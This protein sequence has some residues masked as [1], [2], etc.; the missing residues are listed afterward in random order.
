MAAKEGFSATTVKDS[1]FREIFECN[2][3][4]REASE[5]VVTC[6]GHLFCW[7]CLY[8]WLHV[9]SSRQ[10]C[11]VCK[12]TIEDGDVTPIYGPANSADALWA[13]GASAGEQGERLIPPRPPARRMHRVQRAQRL[14]EMWG[15]R[16]V[17]R[18]ENP[19]ERDA[20]PFMEDQPPRPDGDVQQML[21]LVSSIP[22]P[23]ET[24]PQSI[25]VTDPVAD[26][27][28]DTNLVIHFETG[29]SRRGDNIQGNILTHLDQRQRNGL[30]SL[31]NLHEPNDA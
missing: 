6:C 2:I 12:G 27:F 13:E 29:G 31:Q 7:P 18:G 8:M 17:R 22:L 19:L 9:H 23:D 24:G 21:Q 28:E 20:L 3:C 26:D 10:S 16:G 15:G 30:N 11:P 5:A 4:F 1:A 14:D 25:V